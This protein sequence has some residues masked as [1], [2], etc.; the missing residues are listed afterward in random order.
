[1]IHRASCVERPPR[2]L[3]F[4]RPAL[5]RSGRA[6]LRASR[7]PMPVRTELRPGAVR[8]CRCSTAGFVPFS[9]RHHGSSSPFGG[10]SA[11]GA[12]WAAWKH[13]FS[14]ESRGF[15][16]VAS[17]KQ[18]SWLSLVRVTPC[19]ARPGK[20]DD[21]SGGERGRTSASSVEPYAGREGWAARD[22]STGPKKAGRQAAPGATPAWRSFSS[23]SS[24]SSSI[25]CTSPP[26][27]PA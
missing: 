6:S 18:V 17:V 10:G 23:S 1:V 15:R 13:V 19:C 25:I 3:C 12:R 14:P 22:S 27:P 21:L 5:R 4:A 11:F 26:A 24:K 16:D 20:P 9:L 2:A 8:S 7:V